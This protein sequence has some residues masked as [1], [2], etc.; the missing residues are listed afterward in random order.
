MAKGAPTEECR[1]NIWLMWRLW[2][3]SQHKKIW[4]G[5][6]A[7]TWNAL[8]RA[9][10]HSERSTIASGRQVHLPWKH[11][12]ES[13]AHWW[14]SQCQDSQSQCSIWPTTRKHL[15]TKWNQTWHKAES[16]QICDAATS[17]IRMWKL[18]SL[19]TICLRKLLKIKRQDRIQTQ[20]SWKEYGC[21][22]YILFCKWHN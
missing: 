2:S 14:W 1:S 19:P 15:E 10:H 7:S 11:I 20:M 3:H 22:V 5:I 6:S 16:L 21:K 8:H 13:R 9:Y 12:V 4:D 18:D 17:I